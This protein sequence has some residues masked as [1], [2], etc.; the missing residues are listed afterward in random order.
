[1]RLFVHSA[2]VPAA[3]AWN[4]LW[5][6]AR[7]LLSGRPGLTV[8]AIVLHGWFK[9]L[10]QAS[11]FQERQE[12]IMLE[13]HAA[14]FQERP[15]PAG[16]SIRPM[17]FDD[18]PAVTRLDVQAFAPLWQNSLPSLQRAFSQAG[19]ATVAWADDQIIGYQISTKNPFGAHLARLAVSPAHQ[20]RGLGYALVQDLLRELNQTGIKRLT[21]NTQNDNLSSLALYQKMGFS[22]T[23]ERYPVFTYPL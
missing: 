7:P 4:I 8:A 2:A 23:G 21:V 19:S 20:G 15:I 13:H 22:P 9:E 14:P 18:L 3:E 11:S 6:T 16:V 1:V 12:I 5:E 10:L 17:N